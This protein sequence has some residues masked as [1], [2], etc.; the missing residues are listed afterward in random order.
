MVPPV[1]L[2]A[3]ARSE[4]RR[5]ALTAEFD[6]RI[7]KPIVSTE[8]LAAV[9]R[10]ASYAGWTVIVRPTWRSSDVEIEGL[11][12][13]RQILAIIRNYPTAARARP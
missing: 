6:M 12:F 10:L 3:C 5:R 2:T 13:L 4:D 1:A 8:L 11:N 9:A 7:A